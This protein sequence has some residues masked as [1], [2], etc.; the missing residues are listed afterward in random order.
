MKI[1]LTVEDVSQFLSISRFTIYSKRSRN[2]MP[3]AYRIGRS[4]RFASC[5]V[6]RMAE[7]EDTHE[8]DDDAAAEHSGHPLA[9]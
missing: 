9:G 1:L 2:E 6:A 3:R 5:D 4:I 8:R 7:L